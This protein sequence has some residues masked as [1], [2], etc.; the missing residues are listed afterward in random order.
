[1][2]D[3]EKPTKV[4]VTL[5]TCQQY[6]KTI[7]TGVGGLTSVGLLTNLPEPYNVW[8]GLGTALLTTFATYKVRNAR[9]PAEQTSA[10]YPDALKTEPDDALG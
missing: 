4:R 3:H 9:P 5:A 7:V 10:G 8:V 1:M 2:G 6:A